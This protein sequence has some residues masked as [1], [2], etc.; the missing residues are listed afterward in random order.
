MA[1]I[2]VIS[3]DEALTWMVAIQAATNWTRWMSGSDTCSILLS[4]KPRR[5]PQIGKN[6]MRAGALPPSSNSIIEEYNSHREY[7]ELDNGFYAILGSF[8]E[9]IV[10]ATGSQ[11]RVKILLNRANHALPL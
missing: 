4:Q 9:Q 8:L 11:G 5:R 10:D 6:N 7:T 2:T 3:E 1:V